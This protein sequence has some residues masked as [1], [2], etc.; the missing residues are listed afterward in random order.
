MFARG[1]Q[2]RRRHL[3]GVMASLEDHHAFPV[4]LHGNENTTSPWNP[5]DFEWHTTVVHLKR[6]QVER[7][8][9]LHPRDDVLHAREDNPGPVVWFHST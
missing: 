4:M 6:P 8:T 5:D 2:D 3:W 1:L 9:Q 7:I